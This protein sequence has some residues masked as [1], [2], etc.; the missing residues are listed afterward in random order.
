[1]SAI[2]VVAVKAPAIERSQDNP[3]SAAALLFSKYQ[4][5][6]HWELPKFGLKDV[7]DLT[8]IVCAE[9]ENSHA[10][11]VPVL[12]HRVDKLEPHASEGCVLP[13]TTRLPRLGLN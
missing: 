1:V 2:D 11:S 5:I 13:A 8:A 10:K 3:H 4:T 7:G 6:L 12:G 9:L